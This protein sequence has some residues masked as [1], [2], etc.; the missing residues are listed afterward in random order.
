MLFFDLLMLYSKQRV[1]LTLCYVAMASL[2]SLNASNSSFFQEFTDGETL[3]HSEEETDG[4]QLSNVP[5]LVIVS[6]RV[7]YHSSLVKLANPGVAVVVYNYESTS[8]SHIL[9][10]IGAKLKARKALCIAFVVHGDPG[11]FKL[12]KQY[13]G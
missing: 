8:L 7:K 3:H 11:I 13:V 5:P 10:M 6:N 9:K 4:D 2:S 12:N 1:G